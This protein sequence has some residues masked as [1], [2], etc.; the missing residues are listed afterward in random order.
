MEGGVMPISAKPGVCI[1]IA[2]IGAMR[3]NSC[4]P[5]VTK[6][7]TVGITCVDGMR[8]RVVGDP[9]LVTRRRGLRHATVGLTLWKR[10]R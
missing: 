5:M 10:L 9:E 4:F 6:V 3:L 1:R 2:V 7:Y 8:V